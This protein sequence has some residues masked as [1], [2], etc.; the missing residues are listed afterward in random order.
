V[1]PKLALLDPKHVKRFQ[2]EARTAA[3]LHRTNIV[4]VFGVGEQDGFQYYVMQYIDGA[5]LDRVL[6]R[7]ERATAQYLAHRCGR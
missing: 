2:R 5:G 7:L 6:A 4:P 3:G 1:L